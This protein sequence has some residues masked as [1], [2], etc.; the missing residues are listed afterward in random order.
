MAHTNVFNFLAEDCD[1][2]IMRICAT[3]SSMSFPWKRGRGGVILGMVYWSLKP[4]VKV[5][6]TCGGGRADKSCVILKLYCGIHL[7]TE[8]NHGKSHPG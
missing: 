2:A 6:V 1:K 7:I 3:G 5:F 8:R 4:K